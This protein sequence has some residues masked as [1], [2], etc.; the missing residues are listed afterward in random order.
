MDYW[1]E[2]DLIKPQSIIVSAA[3]KFPYKDGEII[4]TGAR[5]WDIIMRKTV[6]AIGIDDKMC[7]QGFINQ[8]GE[9][10]TR[11]EAM[12]VVKENGQPFKEERNG[13]QSKELYSEGIY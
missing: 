4:I 13:K 6:D 10:L 2:N 1:G 12:K 5:H 9:F 3:N 11:K 8:F 7:E